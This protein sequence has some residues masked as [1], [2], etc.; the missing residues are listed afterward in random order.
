[1][2]LFEQEI[3]RANRNFICVSFDLQKLLNTPQ[4]QNMNLYY[5]RKYSM[6]NLTIYESGSH[7][8][9]AYLWGETTGARS[10]NKIVTCVYKYLLDLDEKGIYKSVYFFCDSFSGQNKNRAMLAMIHSTHFEFIEE[11][12]ITFLLPGHTYMP[13]DSIHATIERFVKN[14]TVWALSEWSTLITNAR[15]KPLPIVVKNLQYSDFIDWK[16]LAAQFFTQVLK[17]TDEEVVHIT[18]VKS[19]LFTK[20]L[21]GLHEIHVFFTYKSE[22]NPKILKLKKNKKKYCRIITVL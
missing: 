21:D 10:C 12:K 9:L 17:T 14:K 3:S 2:F 15:I 7:N 6:F 1:M 19:F 22:E 11:I 20:P 13:V 4:E 18:K 5:S 8:A 16:K